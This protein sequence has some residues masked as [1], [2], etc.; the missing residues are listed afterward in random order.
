MTTKIINIHGVNA[1]QA[2][3]A[4]ARRQ[5]PWTGNMDEDEIGR[6]GGLLIAALIRCANERRLQLNDMSKELGVSYGYVNQLRNGVRQINQVSDDFAL[7]CARFL[8]VPRLTVLMM[9]GRLSA[10]DLFEHEEMMGTELERAMAYICDDPQW[11][12]LVTQ[13]LRHS[14]SDTKFVVVRMYEKA[15]GKVLMRAALDYK[16]LSAELET[17]QRVHDARTAAVTANIAKKQGGLHTVD[18]CP[19]LKASQD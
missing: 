12:P 16:A 10:A 19:D 6:P 14:G 3:A 5:A 17:L 13:E 15:T 8:G 2:E 7:S 18:S 4:I 1:E 11:G 9:A